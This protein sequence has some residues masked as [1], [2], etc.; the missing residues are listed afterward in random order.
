MLPLLIIPVLLSLVQPFSIVLRSTAGLIVLQ[1]LI[2]VWVICLLASAASISKGL[3]M[4]RTAL[5]SLAV[6]YLN[7]TAILLTLQLGLF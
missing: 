5:I 4:E 6:M 7:I 1:I 2:Q 3:R